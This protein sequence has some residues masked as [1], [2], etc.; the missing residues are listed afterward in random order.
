MKKKNIEESA[1]FEDLRDPEFA[2]SYL[3][4][5]LLEDNLDS[6]LI[7]VRNVAKAAGGMSKLSKATD[8]G[9][10]SMYKTLSE[11]GNPQFATLQSILK[12]LGLRFSVITDPDDQEAAQSIEMG[13]N[14]SLILLRTFSSDPEAQICKA[15]LESHGI[16]SAVF[17]DDLGG[18]H[19]HFQLTQGV[20]LMVRNGDREKAQKILSDL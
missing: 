5:M 6:F 1:L 2:A 9:R 19:P 13:D 17:G 12:G 18:T 14:D 15:K 8:L 3:E 10:E 16:F 11:D 7:A 4:D 20:R